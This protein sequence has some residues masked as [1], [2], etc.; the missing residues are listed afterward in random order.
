MNTQQTIEQLRFFQPDVPILLSSGYDENDVLRRLD[1]S[2]L[3][4]FLHKPYT[5]SQLSEKVKAGIAQTVASS[6]AAGA[7]DRRH[8]H[9]I[10]RAPVR[11][12][13]VH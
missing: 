11:G 5:P 3:L 12:V 4:G 1:N 9:S 13:Q 2:H 6:S 8:S 7:I 10:G